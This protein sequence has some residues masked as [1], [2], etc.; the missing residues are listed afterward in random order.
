MG[1]WKEQPQSGVVPPEKIVYEVSE[2]VIV[3]AVQRE[4]L[5]VEKARLQAQIATID[6]DLATIAELQK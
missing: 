6:E 2:V 4:A 5:L 1:T 3:R